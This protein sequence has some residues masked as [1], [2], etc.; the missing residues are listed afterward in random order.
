MSSDSSASQEGGDA[1][2]QRLNAR[3]LRRLQDRAEWDAFWA[4][5]KIEAEGSWFRTFK[6]F[7]QRVFDGTI[8]FVREKIAEPLHDKYRMPY[9][10]RKITR[11]PEIDMCGVN[12]HSCIYEANE[13]YR[14]D[15]MIDW[16][17]LNVLKVRVDQCAFYYR[18]HPTK[19]QCAQLIE[20]AE[21]AD[22]NFFIKYGELGAE[23]DVR[24]AYMK[25]KHRMVWERRNP[26]IMQARE[27]KRQEYEEKKKNGEFDMSFW[28][29]G[30][31]FMDKKTYDVHIGDVPVKPIGESDKPLS[32]DWE[33]YK[34]V[35]QDPEFDKE[36]GKK[37]HSVIWPGIY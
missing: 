18:D 5:K 37:S 20:D 21:E 32:R 9:Y 3:H 30:L 16:N 10:Q 35:A 1:V 26:E 31:W 6:L 23:S 7:G 33:Y 17:I 36:Q 11:V 8:C 28:K 19:H 25:Q 4:I 15:K 24:D 14:L 29:K 22:L 12:D 27:R 13:Q 2:A 34:H